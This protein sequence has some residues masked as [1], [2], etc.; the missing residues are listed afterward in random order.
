MRQS[1]TCLLI[2]F[3]CSLQY[4]V[5]MEKVWCP[6]YLKQPFRG[7][8]RK[9]CSDNMQQIYRR[10]PLPKCNFNKVAKQ[11]YYN[12]TSARVFSFKFASYFQNTFSWEHLWMA[13]SEMCTLNLLLIL[14][15]ITLTII[16]IEKHLLVCSNSFN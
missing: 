10:T 11:L 14:V 15:S 16:D 1:L 3:P 5:K 13:A 9:K 6:K 2:K 8:L 7:V 12:N 4:A